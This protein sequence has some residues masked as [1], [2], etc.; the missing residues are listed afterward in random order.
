MTI[1]KKNIMTAEITDE[2]LNMI[3]GGLRCERQE[4]EQTE[5]PDDFDI[6][7]LPVLPL[8]NLA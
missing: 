4:A 1:E 3:N 6:T 5:I 7:I 2:Q 8:D